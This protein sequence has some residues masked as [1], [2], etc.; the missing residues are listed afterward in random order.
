MAS[1]LTPRRRQDEL[2]DPAVRVLP[3]EHMP[4]WDGRLLPPPPGRAPG[5]PAAVLVGGFVLVALLS[6]AWGYSMGSPGTDGPKVTETVA[7]E[8]EKP[9]TTPT[10]AATPRASSASSLVRETTTAFFR[11]TPGHAV[12]EGAAEYLNRNVVRSLTADADGYLWTAGPGGVVRWDPRDGTTVPY[13]LPDGTGPLDARGIAVAQDGDVWVTTPGRISHW[14]GD[15]WLFDGRIGAGDGVAVLD[16]VAVTDDGSVWA[17]SDRRPSASDAEEA[18]HLHHSRGTFEGR[19]DSSVLPANVAQ[20]VPEGDSLWVVAGGQVWRHWSGVWTREIFSSGRWITAIAIQPG[21]GR[22]VLVGF[23]DGGVSAWDGD[24]LLDMGAGGDGLVPAGSQGEVG[25]LTV[26]EDLVPWALVVSWRADGA[27]QEL[28]RLDNFSRYPVPTADPWTESPMVAANGKLWL[29]TPDGLVG[30][31]GSGW[32]TLRITDEEPTYRGGLMAVDAAGDLW[33]VDGGSLVRWDG[34]SRTTLTM[35]DL[36]WAGSDVGSSTWVTAAP[37]GRLWAG[38][39]CATSV[40]DRGVWVAVGRPED[41]RACWPWTAVAG[42][43]GSLW[44]LA[45]DGGDTRLHRFDGEAWSTLE[46]PT[47][48]V[49]S[50]AL[51]PDNTLWAAGEGVSSLEDGEWNLRL[52]GVN[53]TTVASG[54]V[55]SVWAAEQCW[56]CPEAASGLWQWVDGAWTREGTFT[57]SNLVMASDGTGWAIVEGTDDTGGLW[58]NAG[59]GGGFRPLLADETLYTMAL[60]RNGGV[61]VGGD[62]RL[63][64]VTGP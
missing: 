60:D 46:L 20:L 42:I 3:P 17:S 47:H 54:V 37:D 43:D 63:L 57:V 1:R 7:A 40:L 15:E 62:A 6:V 9:Q 31:D 58:R 14:D 18:H 52:G 56:E 38:A 64:H 50:I 36:G 41:R 39:S 26:D 61:W 28:V 5:V 10:S 25:A 24:E 32:S 35:E 45:G 34:T 55:G 12:P 53:V 2:G 44:M 22:S 13:T 27:T 59:S 4:Q 11:A 8:P 23:E 16:E 30:F 21:P 33:M 51:S 19:V 29:G 48:A 49:W